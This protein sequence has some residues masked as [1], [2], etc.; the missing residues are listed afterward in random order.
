MF[1]SILS[2]N[3]WVKF[4]RHVGFDETRRD[5]IDRD[6]PAAHFLRDRFR[7]SDQPRFRSHVIRLAGIP[8]LAHHRR[9]ID[10]PCP[11]ARASCHAAPVESPEKRRSSWSRSRV[12]I[13]FFHPQRQTVF[14]DAGI[15]DQNRNGPEIFSRLRDS[16][17]DGFRDWPDPSTTG[18]ASRP[19]ERI[20]PASASS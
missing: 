15:V 4:L 1:T 13:L 3:S 2:F 14:G 10:D 9:N 11:S 8:H 16:F 19:W 18:K 6:I 7:Q 20:S 17:L 5:G 12:P